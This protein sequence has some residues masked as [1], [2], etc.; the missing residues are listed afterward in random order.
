MASDGREY[1]RQNRE[2]RERLVRL[3]QLL[4]APHWGAR[5]PNGWTVA[6]AFGHLGFWDRVTLAAIERY[7]REGVTPVKNDFHLINGVLPALFER[8]S[9]EQC[10]SWA[11]DSAEAVDARIAALSPAMVE[12]IIQKDGER[13]IHRHIHRRNHLDQIESALRLAD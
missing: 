5:L 11:V 9:V 1:E 6:A 12:E 13:R 2:Q 4:D 8:M 10:R 7:E 3:G